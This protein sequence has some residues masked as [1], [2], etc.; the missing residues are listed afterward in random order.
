MGSVIKGGGESFALK[1]SARTSQSF[2]ISG[3][4]Q[5]VKEWLLSQKKNFQIFTAVWK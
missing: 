3:Y 4:Y 2:L 5:K 1:G